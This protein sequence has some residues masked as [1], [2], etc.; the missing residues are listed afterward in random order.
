MLIDTHLTLLRTVHRFWK[1][2]SQR[3]PDQCGSYGGGSSSNQ[4]GKMVP[5][6][7]SQRPARDEMDEMIADEQQR[8]KDVREMEQKEEDHL[9]A[10]YKL[11]KTEE[12]KLKHLYEMKQNRP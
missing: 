7:Q 11:E 10:L 2:S 1:M 6:V 9:K 3:N 8:L 4:R 5:C 12:A